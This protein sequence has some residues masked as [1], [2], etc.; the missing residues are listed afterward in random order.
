VQSKSKTMANIR[1]KQKVSVREKVATK[2]RKSL[3]LDWYDGNGKRTKE[4]LGLFILENPKNPFEKQSN[5]DVLEKAEY[6]RVEKEAQYFKGEAEE[7]KEQKLNKNQHFIEYFEKYIIN[8]D[9]KDLRVMRA[10]LGQFK[11]FAP[12]N[13]TAKEITESLCTSF[14]TYLDK[15]LNGDTP[16]TYFARFKKM[17]R[18]AKR[19]KLFRDSPAQE[20]KNTKNDTSLTKAVLTIDEIQLLANTH[21]GNSE[22]K[23]AFLFC[24]N[25]GLR[26]VDIKAL[27]WNHIKDNVLKIEQAKTKDK[28]SDGGMVEVTLNDTAIKL[29]GQPADKET[30]VFNLNSH[31]STVDILKYWVKRAGI[32]KHI[33]FHCA[34]HTFG[35]L[36]AYY[37][38]DIYTISKLL[39]HTSLKHTVKYVRESKELKIKATNSIP[40]LEL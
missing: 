23:R 3:Y 25:T 24:C 16:S 26:F 8:Y 32:E 39:G 17:L 9:K 15:T 18:Q 5:K 13:I 30:L 1:V 20:I 19:D 34:R 29:L 38:N 7:A 40:A 10:V 31:N 4:Y 37:E 21:C 33:T 2:N 12:K 36:L 35:T 6:Y 11:D 14:K 28:A 22:V 27:Q